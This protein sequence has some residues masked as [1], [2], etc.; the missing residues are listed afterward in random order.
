MFRNGTVVAKKKIS[1]DM[2]VAHS[3]GQNGDDQFPWFQICQ[4]AA[5]TAPSGFLLKYDIQAVKVRA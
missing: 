3:V 5:E 2:G 1:G 4:Y